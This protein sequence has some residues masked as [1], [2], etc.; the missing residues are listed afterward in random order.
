MLSLA[1]LGSLAVC[2]LA[3][4]AQAYDNDAMRSKAVYQVL[5]DRFATSDGSTTQPCDVSAM[6]YCGGTYKGLAGKL[7]YIKGMGFD[8]I[9]ISPIVSNIG[10]NTSLGESY[11]GYWTQD[12]YSLNEAFGSEADLKDLIS[13]AKAKDMGIMVDVV[14]NHVAATASGNFIPNDSYGPFNSTA[15]YHPFCWVDDY[16]NQTNV[17]QCSLGN[18]D[19]TLQDLDTE[20]PNVVQVFNS[21][22]KGLIADYGFEAIRID[23]VKHVRKDFWPAFVDAAGVYAVGEVLDG[24]PPYV[25]A[26]QKQ[27]M[28]SVFNYPVYFPL[29]AAFNSTSGNMSALSEMVTTLT[30]T[31]DDTTMLG[32]FLDNHDNS[33]FEATVNDKMLI[34]N[35]ATFPFVSD[36]IPY[37]YYGQEQGFTGGEIDYENR[38]AMWLSNFNTETDMYKHFGKLNTARSVMG[39]AQPSFYTTKASIADSTDSEIAISKPPMLSVLSNRG[40][41]SGSN[42]LK[43]NNLAYDANTQLLDVI[44]CKTYSTNGDKS[45]DVTVQDGAPQVFVPASL[46]QD[47]K[48][49]SSTATGSSSG[50]D[51]KSAGFVDAKIPVVAGAMTVLAGLFLTMF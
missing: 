20:D 34:M 43:L 8:V 38:E 28:D 26:Y 50:G 35:A 30:T 24:Y 33:R 2:S 47:N 42:T 18:T 13:Q 32:N 6:S 14:V 48:I 3:G 36:G 5:T 22:I 11:H 41:G 19:V 7:D 10:G 27:S 21:W 16:N 15:Q 25:A 4:L 51:S 23:T 1:T 39:Q 29:K 17:E 9:W 46:N 45:L 37:V 31:F 49:C 12:I 40:A 44:G